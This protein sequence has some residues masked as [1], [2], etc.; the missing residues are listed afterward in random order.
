MSSIKVDIGVSCRFLS[1]S[2][3]MLSDASLSIFLS[4]L[5]IA[6]TC[7]ISGQAISGRVAFRAMTA[8]GI[9]RKRPPLT[10]PDR[11]PFM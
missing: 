4:K 1:S 6:H 2:Y 10:K 8:A 9:L 5:G 11:R 3:S 7:D